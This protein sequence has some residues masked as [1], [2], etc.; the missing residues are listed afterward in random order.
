MAARTNVLIGLGGGIAAYKVCEVISQLVQAGAQVRCLYTAAAEQFIAPLTL[1]T[2]SR[3][4]AYGDALLWSAS[5]G[6]PLHIEL[7]EWAQVFLLAPLT[8]NTLAKLALGLA[9]NLLTNTVLAS[10]CPVLLAPAMNTDM[11][12]QQTVQRNWQGVQQDPRYHAIAPGSGLLA[13]DRVG[14]GRLAEPRELVAAVQSL[15]H[16][17]GDRDLAGQRVLITA[18]STREHLDPV[19]FLSNPATG[20]MG[21]ALARAACHRGAQV[22]LIHGPLALELPPHPQVQTLAVTSAA[23][24]RAAV[25]AQSDLADW[26]LLAAAVADQRPVSQADHKLPKQALPEALPLEP[27]PDIAL[28]LGQ[29]RRSSQRFIGFAAQTGAVRAPAWDK[30]QRKG[31]DVIAA[32]AVDQPGA[33]F[34][35]ETN[36][37]LLLAADGREQ[38]LPLGTKLAIAH[39]IFDFAQ[40]RS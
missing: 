22:S 18:G 29:R 35:S 23:E 39:Q 5:Q 19:R 12:E 10:R 27:T 28:E 11:W 38:A 17:G 30:L 15:L 14:P 20:K 3:H 2:L 13:C 4:P 37:M 36:Q 7:G 6:R 40:G 9:D 24:M 34:G 16:T 32:N 26:L 1:A 25:L 8:A 33:G 31:F 21:L